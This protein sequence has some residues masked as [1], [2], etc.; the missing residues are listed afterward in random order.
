MAREAAQHI[1][2]RACKCY[3]AS[4]GSNAVIEFLKVRETPGKEIVHLDRHARASPDDHQTDVWAMIDDLTVV[5]ESSR[6][7]GQQI[8]IALHVFG[9]E[10]ESVDPER[11]I[12]EAAG[13][14]IRA[15]AVQ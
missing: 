8:E 3:L 15:L 10:G 14:V 7:E 13:D 2:V 11:L 6:S 1:P 12:A 9:C 5:S 4:D